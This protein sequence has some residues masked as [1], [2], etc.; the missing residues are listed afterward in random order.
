MMK[1]FFLAV[2]SVITFASCDPATFQ[3]AMD[4]VM[5]TTGKGY[6][7]VGSTPRYGIPPR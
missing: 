2:A 7:K 5:A 6:P 4:T 1:R 3:Q